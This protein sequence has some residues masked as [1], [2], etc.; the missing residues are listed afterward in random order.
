MPADHDRAALGLIE[1]RT[2]GAGSGSAGQDLWPPSASASALDVLGS[3]PGYYGDK[4]GLSRK[5]G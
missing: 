1:T 5:T 4:T 3:A 2:T